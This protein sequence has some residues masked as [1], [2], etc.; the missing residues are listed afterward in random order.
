MGL[1]LH[2]WHGYVDWLAAVWDL[3]G[4]RHWDYMVIVAIATDGL[5]V[6]VGAFG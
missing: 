6:G 1:G 4:S 5:L 3:H 2:C